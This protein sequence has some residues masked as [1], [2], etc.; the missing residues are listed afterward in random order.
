MNISNNYYNQKII[1]V[2]RTRFNRKHSSENR[3][4]PD[5]A[6]RPVKPGTGQGTGPGVEKKPPFEKP[7]RNR[8]E[9]SG[10]RQTGKTGLI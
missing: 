1:F 10:N 7:G 5:R 2:M 8:F 3:T 6:V 4:G 9:P